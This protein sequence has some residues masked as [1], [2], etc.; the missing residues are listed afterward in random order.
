MPGDSSKGFLAIYGGS[1]VR[2][3][4]MPWRQAFGPDEIAHLMS[5]IEYYQAREEDPPYQGYFEQKFCDAFADFMGGGF[6]DAVAT[7]TASIYIALEALQLPRGSEVI[8]SPV[9][10][11]GPLNCI[12]LQGLVPVL[13]DSAPNSFNI[14]VDQFLERVT[15]NTS[16]ILAVHCAGEPLEID[17]LVSEAHKRNIRVLEDCSQAPG[18]TWKG[19]KVGSFGDIAA[20]S[21]MY[22]KTLNTGSSGGLVY[23]KDEEMYR[24]ALAYADR[25]K[26]V[27]KED[28]N[29]CDPTHAVFPA[30]N[31]NTGELSCAIGLSSLKRLQEAVD[32]RVSFLSRLIGL[33]ESE[34][35]VCK[36]YAFHKG[37]SPFFFPVFVDREKL[38]CSKITFAQAVAAEGIG[39]NPHYGCVVS[40]WPWARP[41]LSD[42][43]VT[44]NALSTRD[45]SFN[46]FLNERYGEEEAQDTLAAILKVEKYF[47][48]K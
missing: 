28:I 43:F 1:R 31:F 16:A 25:G 5:V 48:K 26:S 45:R 32:K 41:Y 9:T 19:R 21:T 12:I 22:R 24:R 29:L 10:D 36:P 30:L 18:A 6:A 3:K 42:D 11:S 35:E 34:S 15:P 13:A 46:L 4:K 39:L 27:W 38:N 40:S 2:Q 14:G 33:I 8:I 20:F 47:M 17:K 37:F 44:A 23:A 7:G